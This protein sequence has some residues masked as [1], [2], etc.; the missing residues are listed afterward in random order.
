MESKKKNGHGK[1]MGKNCKVC[2]NPV[3]CKLP[4]EKVDGTH[5]VSIFCT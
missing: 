2:G 1:V 4:G 5:V 3:I